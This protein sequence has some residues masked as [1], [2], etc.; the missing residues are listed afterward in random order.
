[1]DQAL[2]IVDAVGQGEI[3]LIATC[4]KVERLSPEFRSRFQLATW[5]FD[6]PTD[7]ERATIWGI[8]RKRFSI[9]ES[10]PKPEDEGWV[11]REIESCCQL[12]Y[13]LQIP[14]MEASEY[15]TPSI[16]SNY[17]AISNLRSQANGRYLSASYAGSYRHKASATIEGAARAIEVD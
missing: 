4:N 8:H 5:F 3:L 9:D 11:G 14:L 17:E 16:K 15:I 10:D 12:S 2:K 7:A 13:L 6:L 1:M